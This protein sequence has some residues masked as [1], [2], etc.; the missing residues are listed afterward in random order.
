MVDF[1]QKVEIYDVVKGRAELFSREKAI[2]LEEINKGLRDRLDQ[3]MDLSTTRVE[4]FQACLR[5]CQVVE[6]RI[7][8]PS[9]I[10]GEF[11]ELNLDN[12]SLTDL[13]ISSGC[14]AEEDE[15]EESPVVT[16]SFKIFHC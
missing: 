2:I 3:T 12:N 9:T 5:M 15:E 7:Y 6:G 13:A 4:N 16:P 1:K 11:A 10:T 8:R 14:N